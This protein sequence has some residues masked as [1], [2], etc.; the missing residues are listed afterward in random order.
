MHLFQPENVKTDGH[1]TDS[2]L[3]VNMP[4][5]TELINL[6]STMNVFILAVELLCYTGNFLS[7]MIA[8]NIYRMENK[9]KMNKMFLG[10]FLIDCVIGLI[11]PFFLFKLL[12]ERLEF[13]VW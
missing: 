2:H 4:L 12:R 11:H 1:N 5:S 6:G 13:K 8:R 7:G 10:Y 3:N 9:T